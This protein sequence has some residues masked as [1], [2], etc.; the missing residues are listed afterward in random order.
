MYDA[1]LQGGA[2]IA[3]EATVTE[4]RAEARWATRAGWCVWLGGGEAD[5][6]CD[7]KEM[8]IGDKVRA[9]AV[10]A[11]W[12]DIER[13]RELFRWKWKHPEHINL[14]EMRT[15]LAAVRRAVRDKRA[16]GKRIMLIGDSLVTIG[17]F[18]K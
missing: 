9:P 5:I 15:G 4:Q 14:L 13:W 12:D 16:W 8:V 2:V 10:G 3:T 11:N 6:D 17:A 18:S 7:D 1:S